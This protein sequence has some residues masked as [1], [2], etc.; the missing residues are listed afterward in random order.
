[1]QSILTLLLSL[2][3]PSAFTLPYPSSPFAAESIFD[4]GHDS[5][6]FIREAGD[7]NEP[8]TRTEQC[9][10]AKYEAFFDRY[11]SCMNAAESVIDEV[12]RF[13]LDKVE[14]H[15]FILLGFEGKLTAIELF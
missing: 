11:D 2:L 12:G 14:T 15:I 3:L 5:G 10:E 6:R 13:C 7:G 4:L 9:P 8:D 1:M